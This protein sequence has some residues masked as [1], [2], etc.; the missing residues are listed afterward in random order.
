LTLYLY[1]LFTHAMKPRYVIFRVILYGVLY[2]NGVNGQTSAPPILDRELIIL[3]PGAGSRGTDT[4]PSAQAQGEFRQ[5]PRPKAITADSA[6][7]ISPRPRA[8][9]TECAVRYEI[10]PMLPVDSVKLFVRHSRGRT[11]TLAVLASP[12]YS[13]LWDCAG[14]PDQDQTHLQFGYLL[15]R[16]DSLIVASPHIPHRWALLRGK[17]AA[18]L[19]PYRIKQLTAVGGFEVDCDTSK[20]NG[21]E[22]AYV[23]AR[24][25]V[26]GG[27]EATFKLLWTSVKL[28]FIAQVRDNSISNGDFVELHLDMRRDRAVFPGINHRSLRFSPRGRSLFFIGEFADGKYAQSDSITRLLTDEAEWKTVIDSGGYIVEAAIPFSLLS[29]FEFPPSKIGFD[30]SVMNADGQTESFVS[31]AGAERFTR[32]SPSRWGTARIDQA[33]PALQFVLIVALFISGFA[34]LAFVFY[35]FISHRQE[36]KEIRIET[37]GESPLTEAVVEHIEKHL[38]NANLRIDDISKSVDK[39]AEEIAAALMGD[40]ECTFGQLLAYR[41][42]KRSQKLMRE[43]ELS[44]EE[45]AARCGFADVDAYR[46]SYIARMKVAPEVSRKAMLERIRED[47][48]AERDD[49]DYDDDTSLG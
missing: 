21:V 35:L 25:S 31:W 26:R 24:D 16:G 10:E 15:Y 12:P 32:Y 5:A 3:K 4:L 29:N 28:Y 44:M 1:A 18:Q 6:N 34:I 22:G 36:S 23:F 46:E 38:S 17:R 42:V 45:I 8:V 49:E 39:P 47:L 20:W 33:A 30:V 14:V 41:R 43:A 40:L 19:R 37:R 11:D 7:I 2:A 48:E 13:V 9:I 27:A